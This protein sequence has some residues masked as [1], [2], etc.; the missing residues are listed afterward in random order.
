M[1]EGGVR[2]RVWAPARRRVELVFEGGA[3]AVALTPE[4]GGYFSVT[5]ATAGPGTLYRFRLDGEGPFPDPASRFQPEGPHGPSRVVDPRGFPWT[6]D[7]WRGS[8][9]RGQVIYEMHVGTFTREGTWAAAMAELAELAAFGI[10]LLE[11]MPVAEFPGRFGWGYDG[12]DLFAPFH[13]YGEPDDLRRFVDRAHAVGLGVILDVVYNHLGPDGNYLSQFA[14]DYFTD[15]HET[16]WGTAIR[17]D[18]P[19]SEPVRELY[20]ANARY[21]IEEYHFDG[22]RLDATQDIHDDSPDPIL[23]CVARE[24]RRAG[25]GRATYLVAENE[26]QHTMLV[27]PPEEGGIGLDALWNDDFHHSALVALTGRS[28]AYYTDYCGSPQ[29]FVSAAKYGYLYQ[30]QRYVWQGQRRGTPTWGLPPWA[31]VAFVQNHDQVANSMRGERLHALSSPG[32]YRAMTAFLLLGPATPML[33][34]GQEF[35][36]TT[37][38]VYFADHEPE[39]GRKVRDGRH[40]F[41]A[42][43]ASMMTPET[44]AQIPDPG[45]L[46]SFERSKLDFAERESHA[47]CYAL[48]RDLLRLRR[49]DPVLAGSEP[50]RVDGAVL[51]EAA[52]VLRFCGA[53]EAPEVPGDRLLIVNLGNDRHLTPAP[54]PLLA[55][56]EGH[57]WGLLWSSEDP[58]YGGS[59]APE[60]ES[61]REG[62]RL[63]G[64][65]ALFLG[66]HPRKPLEETG[67]REE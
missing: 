64:Q 13:L 42:Q 25:G 30:G 44:Q 36:A 58:A 11:I 31:F 1:P 16:D 39:L 40:R 22:L 62:W 49:E 56:P 54:E 33:F 19:G 15:R 41:L 8:G 52:F 23:A 21:W 5:L 50:P 66:P 27:R 60:P 63:S 3:E 38:F 2:F 29:E 20:L 34:Q 24:V 43:F 46:S 59:G 53:S 26:P 61:E 28:E 48:H 17:F 57:R 45:A 14:P 51:G 35:C 12:V 18:G 4:D 55:P 47:E 67:R 6:D 32:R 10:T 7:G 9:P 37:P 65:A